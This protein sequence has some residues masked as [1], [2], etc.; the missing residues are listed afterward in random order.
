MELL[1]VKQNDI[2]ELCA[3][4]NKGMYIQSFH[5]EREYSIEEDRMQDNLTMSFSPEIDY[6]GEKILKVKF[7][8]VENLVC[9]DIFKC[10]SRPV[11]TINDIS[12]QGYETIRYFVDEAENMFYFYCNDIEYHWEEQKFEA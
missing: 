4:I 8:D 9:D 6:Y 10:I 12:A 7:Y 11:I 5:W 2:N 1:F 3:A